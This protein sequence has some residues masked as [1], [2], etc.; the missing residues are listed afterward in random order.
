MTRKTR[1]AV[2]AGTVLILL[3]ACSPG[4]SD[5]N[6]LHLGKVDFTTPAGTALTIPPDQLLAA[7]GGVTPVAFG[8]PAHGKMSYGAN[9]AMIYTPDAGFT[10]TDQLTVTVS[11]AVKLYAEDQLPLATIGG[12]AIKASAHG[13]GIAAVPGSTDEIYGLTDRGPNVDGR[14]PNEKVIPVPDYN[15]QIA[16]LKLADGVATVERTITLHG[17]DGTPLVGLVDPHANTGEA[18]VDLNGAPLPPSDYGVDTEGLAATPDGT[19]WVSDEYGPYIIH[20]DAKGKELERLSPFDGTL[21]REL[22]LRAPN[23]GMEGL[24]MTPDGNTL[25]G[26]MQSAIQ[27]PG[28]QGVAKSV[29]VTRIV[30][31][32]LVDRNIV[33]EYL[34]PLANP[35]QTNVAVSEITALSATEFLID[36]RDNK[37]APDGDKKIYLAD[38]AGA[39]DVGPRST[40]PGASY[41]PD[42]GGLLVN[43][44]PLETLVGVGTDADAVV[45]L[46]AAGITVAAKTLKLDLGAL[47][48]SLNAKGDFFGHDKIEGVIT[49]DGGKTLIVANDSDFGLAGLASAVPPFRLKPKMLPNGAQDSGEIL[50]VDTTKLPAK[51]EQMTIPITVG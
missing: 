8:K 10:G 26:I 3:T 1:W 48:R 39:T 20:F 34:Y 37:T 49:P 28:L 14:T 19:F 13:S 30:T 47:V 33:H 50:S 5:S 41:Q 16:K 27:T 11:R 46:K 24:T 4:T 17:P 44:V 23:Q 18:L 43:G 6:A 42:A 40:V 21:P 12:V 29:P 2:A 9:G 38:I 36:E 35:Q 32:N 51:T 15:P 31:I 7:T 22:P 45:R 25:V